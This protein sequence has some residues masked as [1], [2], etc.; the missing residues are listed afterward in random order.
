[1]LLYI[2]YEILHYIYTAIKI[3]QFFYNLED[4]TG[5]VGNEYVE[6]SPLHRELKGRTIIVYPKKYFT[7]II[8]NDFFC[9]H[10]MRQVVNLT[11]Q[12]SLGILIQIVQVL[13]PYSRHRRLKII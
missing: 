1:M 10:F 12:R 8:R 3:K 7:L 6:M 11:V 5:S 13:Q 2:I 9:C 4:V